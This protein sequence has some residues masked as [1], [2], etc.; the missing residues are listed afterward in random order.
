VVV[1]RW[2][3]W[4]HGPAFAKGGRWWLP[5]GRWVVRCVVGN[6]ITL[7]VVLKKEYIFKKTYQRPKETSSTSL[8]PFSV[9]VPTVLVITYLPIVVAGP[10]WLVGGRPASG[11]GAGGAGAGGAGAGAGAGGAGGG[12]A[13][14]GAGGVAG[15]GGAGGAVGGGGCFGVRF[16]LKLLVV[17]KKHT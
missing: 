4:F 5:G 3:W 16:T 13:G 11:A 17:L 6:L 15:A 9:P 7:L 14:A 1:A 8:G 2:C 10:M 12:G